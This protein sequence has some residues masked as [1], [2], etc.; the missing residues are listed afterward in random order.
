MNQNSYRQFDKHNL[1]YE[2]KSRTVPE[3]QQLNLNLVS[4]LD[5]LLLSMDL[6]VHHSHASIVLTQ[7]CFNC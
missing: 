4:A 2:P 6:L 7:Y 1:I 5:H 3:L